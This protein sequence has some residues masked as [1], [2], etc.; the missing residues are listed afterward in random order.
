M[1]ESLHVLIVDDDPMMTKT[2]ADILRVMGYKADV[3]HC[4]PEALDKIKKGKVD[5][6]LTDIKMPDM[7]GVELYEAVK[8]IHPDMP[9]VMMTAYSADKRVKGAVACLNKPLDIEGLIQVLKDVYRSKTAGI[10]GRSEG[11]GG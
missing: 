7:D 1:K 5:C 10:T 6:V 8:A 9:V 11:N 4:G 2:L 3:A